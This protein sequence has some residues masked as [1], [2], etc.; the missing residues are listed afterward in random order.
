MSP[1]RDTMAT[2]SS[3]SNKVTLPKLQEDGSNWVMYKERIQNHLT[4]KGLLRHYTGTAR[5]PVE[6]EEKN[7]KMHKKGNATAMTDV[8]VEAY[9]NLVDTYAQKEAQVREV[10]Y[11]TLSKTVTLQIKGQSTAADA[12]KK[13]TSIFESKGDMTITDTLSKLA[14]THYVDG[15]D[16]RA[17]ITT[18][19]ELQERLAD[20]GHALSD[21]Q[22]SAYVRASLTS[23]YRPLLVSITAASKAA[24]QTLTSDVLIQTIL[25]E[26]D[27]K[28]A[29]KNVD[30][31]RENAAMLAGKGK[32]GGKSKTKGDKTDKKCGNCKKKGHTDEDCFA[33]GGGKEKEAPE[34]WKKKFGKGKEKESKGKSPAANVAEDKEPNTEENYAFLIDSDDVALVCTSDFHEEALKTGIAPRSIIIDCGASSHFT[35][36]RDNLTNYQ[37][38][39]DIPIRAADGRTFSAL[40]RGDMKISFPMGNGKKPTPITLKNVYYSP[41]LAF[42]LVSCT[43]M[44]RLGFKVLLDGSECTIYSP[45]YKVIGVIPETRGLY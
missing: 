11:D 37:E 23:D 7:G 44:T 22:F 34:W 5:K 39:S 32:K 20:M 31:A 6:I 36:D 27:N 10:L 42:T 4:S 12:W 8:E 2:T 38:L 41:H 29:E 13:L 18:L 15:N 45:T 3:S 21:Q 17:H 35:P 1:G 30:N 9:L 19:L 43:R 25:D 16:M 26:A 24:N 14:S 40:G 33:P 28:A